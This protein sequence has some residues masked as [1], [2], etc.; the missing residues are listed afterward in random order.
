M[1]DLL[2]YQEIQ[3]FTEYR[4][5]IARLHIKRYGRGA[6]VPENKS[7]QMRIDEGQ[8]DHFL[9]FITSSLPFG[10]QYALRMAKC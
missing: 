5:K 6:S 4:I 7:P 9:T 1:A 10:Q 8:L 3:R 2:K